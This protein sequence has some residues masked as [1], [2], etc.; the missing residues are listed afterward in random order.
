MKQNEYEN[1]RDEELLMQVAAG[2]DSITDYLCKKYKHLVMKKANALYLIGAE[3]EDLIQEGMIGLFKAIRDY[4]PEKEASFYHFAELC[5]TRQMYH[6]IE[7][8]QRLKHAPLNFYVSLS[9]ETGDETG[10]TL[11]DMLIGASE[12]NPE[13]LMLQQEAYRDFFDRL[14]HLLS[15]M[16]KQV[17]DLYLQGMDYRQIADYLGKT[18]KSID[19]ALQR[20]RGKIGKMER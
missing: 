15:S 9:E 4:S 20:I 14:E 12:Q 19:N 13:R 17:C 1:V 2:N 6:A 5:I 16:E 11:E 10:L 8:S 3:K 7:A 18:P